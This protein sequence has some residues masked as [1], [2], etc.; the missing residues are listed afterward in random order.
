MKLKKAYYYLYYKLYNIGMAISDDFL[1]EW[2]PFVTI[3]ALETMILMEIMIWYIVVTRKSITVPNP[4]AV[5]VPMTIIIAFFNYLF[6]LEKSKWR[7]YIA[8]FEEYDKQKGSLGFWMVLLIVFGVLTG[9]GSPG[10]AENLP[11][12]LLGVWERINIG[13]FMVWL[14]VLAAVLLRRCGKSR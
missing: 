2:K 11:T 3:V 13:V 8:E 10:I 14:M 1:R 7:R 9:L 5:F 12:P 4:S 6:F